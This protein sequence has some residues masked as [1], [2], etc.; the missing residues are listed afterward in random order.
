MRVKT[1]SLIKKI[2]GHKTT[3]LILSLGHITT[4]RLILRYLH[5][6][7]NKNTNPSLVSLGVFL[8][9]KCIFLSEEEEG[10]KEE[11]TVNVR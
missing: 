4:N 5:T 1:L 6:F 3:M 7:R 9:R 2:M 11:E 8:T 10:K